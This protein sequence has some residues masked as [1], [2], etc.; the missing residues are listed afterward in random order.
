MRWT[1]LLKVR[2]I[3]PLEEMSANTNIVYMETA[4][5]GHFGYVEGQSRA[6]AESMHSQ[7]LS[8]LT[9]LASGLWV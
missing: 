8:F 1:W 3:V 6:V 4:S 7:P 2:E 9:D 5:G